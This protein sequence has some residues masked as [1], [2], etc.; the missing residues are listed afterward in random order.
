MKSYR[1]V[2][3]FKFSFLI[4]LLFCIAQ[5]G[6]PNFL[7]AQSI[8]DYKLKIADFDAG[9]I[10]SIISNDFWHFFPSLSKYDTPLKK[11]VFLES[12][13]YKV[14]QSILKQLVPLIEAQK[15]SISFPAKL[16]DYDL[17]TS[18]FDL[19]FGTPNLGFLSY[20]QGNQCPNTIKRFKFK[21]LPI[22]SVRSPETAKNFGINEGKENFLLDNFLSLKIP[23]EKAIIIEENKGKYNINMDFNV[24]GFETCK[25]LFFN[26]NDMRW[27]RITVPVVLTKNINLKLVHKKTKEVSYMKTFE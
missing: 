8:D 14:K 17:K 1:K 22:K 2:T 25:Y 13:E 23:M 6:A 7:L 16:S 26:L 3:K 21:A 10:H 27:Y 4:L 18:S 20:Q 19:E 9:E 12:E 5:I 11:Q 15:Y 24:A